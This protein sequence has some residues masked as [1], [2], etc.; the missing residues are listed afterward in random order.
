MTIINT[1]K[2]TVLAEQAIIAGSLFK[3][4]TG[5]LGRKGV[6]PAQAL[7]I[8]PCRQIHTLFMRFPIDALFV[9]RNNKVVA[10]HANL[11]PWRI[12]PFYFQSRFVIELPVGTVSDSRTKKG[13]Y[14]SIR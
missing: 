6:Q 11:A 4:I 1:T 10:V 13:D 2:N 7:V 14:L 5:L 12:T 9:N 3:R 8:M